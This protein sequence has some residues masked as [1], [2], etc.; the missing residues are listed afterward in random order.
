M[1][2]LLSDPPLPAIEKSPVTSPDARRLAVRSSISRSLAGGIVEAHPLRRG[3]PQQHDRAVLGRRHL[4][5][6]AGE[7][8]ERR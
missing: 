7:D 1:K 5:P 4:L 6:D 3:R 8:Q 2:P